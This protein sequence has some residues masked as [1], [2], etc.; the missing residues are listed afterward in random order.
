[1]QSLLA[2][3]PTGPAGSARYEFGPNAVLSANGLTSLLKEFPDL[4]SS[5]MLPSALIDGHWY[6]FFMVALRYNPIEA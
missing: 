3:G 2:T 6:V 5:E 1:M 4:V